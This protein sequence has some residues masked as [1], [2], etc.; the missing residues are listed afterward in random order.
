MPE[1]RPMQRE[2]SNVEPDAREARLKKR[3]HNALEVLIEARDRLLAQMTDDILSHREVILDGSGQDGIFSFEF[4]EI[5]DRY[6]ARLHALNA[7]LEN[8]EYR[9]PRIA[10]KV[11]TFTTTQRNLRK[12]LNS[13]VSRYDQWDLVDIDVTAL[14]DE[15]LLVVMAFTADEYTE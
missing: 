8:L 15:Q 1:E 5:E 11:E 7:I 13:V 10:H 4:Q 9:R 6:S 2:S 3:R 12:D 14:K